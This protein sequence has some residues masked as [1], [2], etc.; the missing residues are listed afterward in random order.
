MTKRFQDIAPSGSNVK[1]E[2]AWVDF[3]L[4]PAVTMS[5]GW[6]LRGF[7]GG[8]SLGAMIPGALVALV[9]C[10]GLGLPDAICGRMSQKHTF[11]VAEQTT[12]TA[13]LL[14]VRSQSRLAGASLCIDEM[15]GLVVHHRGS[16][17]YGVWTA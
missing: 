13:S 11:K 17:S 12:C 16:C 4:L 6:G 10:R 8:G 3:V 1:Q 2:R 7:I 9:L 15:S 5:V 14:V